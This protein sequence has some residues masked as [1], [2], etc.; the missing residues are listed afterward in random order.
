MV[1][2]KEGHLDMVKFLCLKHADTNI[3]CHGNMAL[4]LAEKWFIVNESLRGVI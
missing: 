3:R 1:A 4:D 2:A